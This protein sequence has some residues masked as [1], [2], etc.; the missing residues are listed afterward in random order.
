MTILLQHLWPA[1]LVA[2]LLGFSFSAI[3]GAGRGL[4]SARLDVMLGA[5]LLLAAGLLLSWLQVVPGRP[6]LWLDL[7]ILCCLAYGAGT[8]LGL[9]ACVTY[10]RLRA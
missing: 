2:G 7:G 9:A 6:G 4:P 1:L 3:F 5:G 10:R 8:L